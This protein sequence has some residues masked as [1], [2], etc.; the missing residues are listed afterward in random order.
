MKQRGVN[1]QRLLITFIILS[2][3]MGAILLASSACSVYMAARQ[4][5]KK[6]L[7]VLEEGTPRSQVIAELGA[8]ALSEEKDGN[9]V[10]I[11]TFKQGYGKG[12][13]AT[14]AVLH[15]LLDIGTFC[16]WELI[17]TPVE[18]VADGTDMK[19]EITYDENDRVK[20]VTTLVRKKTEKEVVAEPPE[21]DER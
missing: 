20:W 15:G 2:L 21:E 1:K 9:K 19:L 17:A 10:D 13:K 3:A 18:M 7:S 11:F 12:T 16:L 4:P 8:P 5:A 14:R 6:D